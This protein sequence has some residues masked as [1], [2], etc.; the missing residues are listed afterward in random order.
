MTNK[1][2]T[3]I[4]TF[5]AVAALLAFGGVRAFAASSL[6]GGASLGL[7]YVSLVSD[8]SDN[9]GNT[10]NDWSEVSFD[11]MNG[12]TFSDLAVLSADF[13]V[14][15]DSCGGGSPRFQIAI[16]DDNDTVSDG[17][18]FVYLGPSPSFSGCTGGWQ[19]SGNLIGNEDAGRWDYTQLGGPLGGYS[20]AT[21]SIQNGK[22]LGISIVVD[23][24]WS[25]AATGGDSEMTTNIDNVVMK[26]LVGSTY[27]FEAPATVTVSIV[28]YVD[29]VHA[30]AG[31]ASSLSFP[32]DATWNAVNIGAG[33]GSFALSTIG[34]NNPNPYEATTA[35]MTSGADY[36]VSEDTS[37]PNVG[38]SCADNKP[39]AL[40]GYS[41]GDTEGAAA[42]AATSSSAVLAGITTDKFIIV[43]NET[44]EDE[45]TLTLQKTVVTDSGG[46]ATDTDWTLSAS[47]PTPISGVEGNASVT[48]AVVLAGT[49]DLSE[50]GPGGYT[51]S[52][53]VC[54]ANGGGPA[55]TFV[56]DDGD[57]ITI[58]DGD[59]I[60]CVITND[61][62]FVPTPPPSPT[63]CDTPGVAPFGYTLQNGT[64][65]N[66]NVTI[67]PFTMFVG[68]GGYDTVNGPADGNY[69]V[70]TG[71]KTD[72]IT[73]GNG[74][75][76]I[77]AGEGHNNITTGNGNGY[78]VTG[79]GN[80]QVKTGNGTQT[81]QAGEGYNWILTGDGDKN[82]TTGSVG[83]QIYTGAGSDTIN[84]GGG[85]NKVN[86]GA[87]NDTITSGP[88]N[89]NIDGGADF[90]TCNG[91]GGYDAITNCEA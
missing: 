73:L 74:D 63:A 55:P 30:T 53:W 24:Y 3:L 44:C 21:A 38:A 49:Y 81:I 69:I 75:F 51:A 5:I 60:T 39:F 4:A 1:L 67:A 19:N 22:I 25:A 59:D 37:G 42:G 52:D 34:F 71:A 27:D 83:D 18:I 89:D 45:G 14:T 29:G 87:G 36:S 15:D 91:G 72:K 84:A 6:F 80:D 56:Q 12:V 65:G 78:I 7:G 68:F 11:D 82:V 47:G 28:K 64:A 90:D 70:C 33:A 26:K 85:Y 23:S 58:S 88:N 43:W 79:S 13:D 54:T 77:S 10:T 31:N 8:G 61:D 17:N 32:I 76:T 86:S 9:P 62:D 66:D 20:G 41:T 48:N 50:S 16:D 40:A 35:E 57:T 2:T 46:T